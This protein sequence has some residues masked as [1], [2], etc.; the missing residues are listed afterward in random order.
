MNRRG[1]FITIAVLLFGT[2]ARPRGRYP[3]ASNA[4]VPRRGLSKPKVWFDEA[5]VITFSR[6]P[7]QF[8]MKRYV[9]YTPVPRTTT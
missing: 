8:P 4:Y 2:T 3:T 1:F 5:S 7:R 9:S 6:D